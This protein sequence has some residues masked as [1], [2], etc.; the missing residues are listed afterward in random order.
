MLHPN[1]VQSADSKGSRANIQAFQQSTLCFGVSG[2]EMKDVGVSKPRPWFTTPLT[3]F[4]NFPHNLPCLHTMHPRPPTTHIKRHH[5]VWILPW[6]AAAGGV[7]ASCNRRRHPPQYLSRQ[8]PSVHDGLH[9]LTHA[10]LDPNSIHR[11][12]RAS[13]CYLRAGNTLLDVD[14]AAERRQYAGK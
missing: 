13:S 7:I 11:P 6:A 14:T 10:H 9:L 12:H 3:S 5:N 8:R 4:A 2:S 1:V